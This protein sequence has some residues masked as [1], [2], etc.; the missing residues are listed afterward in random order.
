[1]SDFTAKDIQERACANVHE[2]VCH[3]PSLTVLTTS[4]ESLTVTECVSYGKEKL[5][6]RTCKIKA[7]S[8]PV[9][10]GPHRLLL[11]FSMATALWPLWS[12]HQ[13]F[14]RA[15]SE[16]PLFLASCPDSQK[17]AYLPYLHVHSDNKAALSSKSK[18]GSVI[19]ECCH[20][21]VGICLP[22]GIYPYALLKAKLCGIEAGDAFKML[23][24]GNF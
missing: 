18:P 2:S 24:S 17:A 3:T 10:H 7:K 9:I 8:K 20:P 13:H 5:N 15:L 16:L 6:P 11:G 14:P 21:T 4:L 19:R 22:L 1:M 23:L 12:V